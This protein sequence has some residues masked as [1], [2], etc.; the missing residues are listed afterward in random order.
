MLLK[1]I[2][3]WSDYQLRSDV[4]IRRHW[5]LVMCAFSFCWWAYGRL[6]TGG[7]AETENDPTS[8]ES[9]GRVERRRPRVSWPQAL[10]A[11]RG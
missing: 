7:P 2:L 10:R 11:L 4:A 8:A 1:H 3:G 6:P 5:E 9:G